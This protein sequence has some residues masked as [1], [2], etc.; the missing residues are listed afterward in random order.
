MQNES[1]TGG[2]QI[3]MPAVWKRGRFHFPGKP[4]VTLLLQQALPANFTPFGR[5][6]INTT[7]DTQQIAVFQLSDIKL[8]ATPD[9]GM[10]G[11]HHGNWLAPGSCVVL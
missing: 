3:R 4:C 9:L 10:V 7:V 8:F 6:W 5:R 2:Q 11:W 1:F